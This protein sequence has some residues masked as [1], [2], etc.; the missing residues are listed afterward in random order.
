MRSDKIHLALSYGNTRFEICNMI[1]KGIRATHT[2]GM[3]TE[4][5]IDRVL[6]LIGP[7]FIG[8]RVTTVVLQRPRR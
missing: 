2:A 7:K 1:A 5:S 8:P 4:E 6:D 3:R